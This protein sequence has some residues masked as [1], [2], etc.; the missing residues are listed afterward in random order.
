MM[1]AE[2]T[3]RQC[4]AADDNRADCVGRWDHAAAPVFLVKSAGATDNQHMVASWIGGQEVLSAHKC[5]I[6]E[7]CGYAAAARDGGR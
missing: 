2:A 5:N 7:S 6:R 4:A 1:G 3:Q